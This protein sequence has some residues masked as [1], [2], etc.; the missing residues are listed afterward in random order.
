VPSLPALH[1]SLSK[2]AAGVLLNVLPMAVHLLRRLRSVFGLVF[3]PGL[4]R[5]WLTC[6]CLFSAVC[7]LLFEV[8]PKCCLTNA[9]IFHQVTESLFTSVDLDSCCCRL[10]FLLCK[11]LLER[12]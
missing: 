10:L 6:T 12:C 7:R 9:S 11:E 1:V 8:L 5:L 2:A 4:T 3:S